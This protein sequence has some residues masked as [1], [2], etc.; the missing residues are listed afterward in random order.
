M[1]SKWIENGLKNLKEEF[2]ERKINKAVE[3]I[4]KFEVEIPSWALGPFGGGRFGNY[5]PPGYAKSIEQKIDDGAFI[6]SLTGSTPY[7]STHILWDF[8]EDGIEGDYEIA[9]RVK[10]ICEERGMKLGTINPTYFLTGS[11]KG[12]FTSPSESVRK[13][14]IEQTILA[15]KIAKELGNGIINLWFPDGSLYPGQID[16]STA[17]IRM[18]ESLLESYKKISKDVHI[19]IEYKVFEPGTYSTTIPDWGTSFLLA[20]SLG[21]NVG[22]LIDLGHHH[23]GTN[24][25][26]I[27]AIL[28]T[29]NIK[30]GFHF[31]TRYVADDDHAVEPNPQVA[32]IFYELV[33]GDVVIGNK[34]WAYMIDQAS[35]RENRIHALL[36]SIDS[37]QISLAKAAIVDSEKIANLM[38]KDEIIL[39]NRLFNNALLNADV[40]PIVAQARIEK[41]LPV[42]PVKAY[43]ESGY[44]KKIERR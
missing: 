10:K 21:K 42:D 8:S 30:C 29:E 4:K 1:D 3:M 32:R 35:G 26:Q 7:I 34:K 44:Q 22:V 6:H 25:E 12:S 15:G 5:T 38:E 41:G 39:A 24:I 19:L 11:E 18:K 40:R 13:R 23:H 2:G 27:V 17:Y 9:V 28:I 16:L 43:I 20:S 31:N 14:Y 37:L 36:H 33:K